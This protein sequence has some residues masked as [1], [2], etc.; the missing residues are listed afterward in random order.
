MPVDAA[1]IEANLNAIRARIASA[2]GRAGRPAGDVR[3][4]AVT[5]YVGADEAAAL[6]AAGCRD[7]GE[8]RPQELWAKAA[9]LSG[10]DIRWHLIG[11]LQRNKVARTLPLVSLLHSVDSPRLLEAIDASAGNIARTVDVLLEVNIS[12]ESAKHG[13]SPVDVEGVL[14]E[15]AK[16]TGVRVLGLMGMAP[17]D[18]GES[19]ARLAFARL[20]QLRDNLRPRLPAGMTL[21]ELSMGMSGDIEAAIAEGATIVRVG[22]ALFE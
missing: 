11:H 18:G 21:D 6:L 4:V 15:A 19:A 9:Q 20:R 22:S 13:L 12:G 17:L 1:R 3:L 16:L 8:S 10:H 7:L 5:K 14:I 2:A